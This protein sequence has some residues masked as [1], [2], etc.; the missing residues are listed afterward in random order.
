MNNNVAASRYVLYGRVSTDR[1]EKQETIK[2]QVD[3]LREYA[4]SKGYVIR[5]EY[6]DDGYSGELLNRPSLDRLMNDA[7]S[8]LFDIVLI[9]SADRLA[10]KLAYQL[11][12]Q[13]TLKRYGVKVLYLNRPDSKDTLEDN[14]LN[15]FEGL[16]A[17]YEKGKILERTHRG[18]LNKA[19]SNQLVTSFAPFGYVYVPV[20]KKN[21]TPARYEIN[22]SEA[23]TV[24]LIFDLFVNSKMSIRTIAKELTKR[25]IKP[26]RSTVW[27]TSSIHKIIRNETYTGTTYYNKNISIEPS[28][29]IGKKYRRVK[30]TGKKLR[31]K[32]LWIPI[33][34]EAHLVIVDRRTFDLAQIQLKTNSEQSPRNVK[35]SYLLRGLIKCGCCDS[36]YQGTSCHGKLYYRCG[37]RHRTFP[38]PRVC[39]RPMITAQRLEDAVWG[40]L[41]EVINNPTVIK[42]QLMK[43]IHHSASQRENIEKKITA[44]DRKIAVTRVQEQRMIDA[45]AEHAL[46]IEQLKLQNSKMETKRR[47]LLYEKQELLKQQELSQSAPSITKGIDDYCAIISNR[48]KSMGNDFTSRRNIMSLAV[49][50]ITLEKDRVRIKGIVP[51]TTSK[52]CNSQKIVSTTSS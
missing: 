18:K 12:L 50:S 45:Y 22:E 4:D 29:N 27:R 21:S 44:L 10:R 41:S 26:N 30:K 24:R 37:N 33:T 42:E 34:L 23:A 46:S 43:L 17:E 36:P 3:A 40:K 28:N 35:H 39:S 49:T 32:E 25:N 7:K 20:D 19:R 38:N 11:L 52:P 5:K 51:L 16:F 9:H 48:L 15:G 14:L 47:E 6:A 8:Q 2:S 1:Q 13:D 31:D